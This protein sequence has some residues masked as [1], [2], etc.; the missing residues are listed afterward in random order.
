M[1]E[2]DLEKPIIFKVALVFCVVGLFLFAVA[3]WDYYQAQKRKE[4][5]GYARA[6]QQAALVAEAINVEMQAEMVMAQD[7]ADKLSSGELPYDQAIDYVQPVFEQEP[8]L[9]GM[10]V[11]FEPYMY[12]PSVKLYAPYFLR[13]GQGKSSLVQIENIYDYTDPSVDTAKWYVQAAEAGT[14]V[15]VDPY[16]GRASDAILIVYSV[17]FS[18]PDD[19]TKLAGIV[20]IA[21]SV[22]NTFKNFIQNAD[23]GYGGYLFLVNGKNKITFHPEL[24]LINEDVGKLAERVK[25]FNLEDA[26]NSGNTGQ[27][28]KYKGTIS[29]HDDQTNGTGKLDTSWLFVHEL[30]NP[31]DWKVVVVI[32][33][34]D[35]TYNPT[36]NIRQLVNL[37]QMALMFFVGLAM[38]VIRVDKMTSIRLMIFSVTLGVYFLVGILWIWYLV[39]SNPELNHQTVLVNEA[40][41]QHAL[42]PMHTAFDSF[43][44][45]HP[46]EVPTGILIENLTMGSQSIKISGYLWQNYPLDF[47]EEAI[48]FPQFTDQIGTLVNEEVYR[49]I[50]D[51]RQ[52]VGW[53]FSSE[54]QQRF[55]NQ[56]YP[57]DQAIIK[58]QIEPSKLSEDYI[59]APAT[60]DYDYMGPGFK[61]GLANNL[62][63]RGWNIRNSFFTYDTAGY[64]TNF[65]LFRQIPKDELPNLVYNVRMTRDILSPIIAYCI[66]IYIV[67]MQIYGISVLK[68]EN[69][70]QVLS[71]AAALF[72]VVAITHNS[73]RETV[74]VNGVVYL[75][76]YFILLYLTILA[77]SINAI[78]WAADI[79]VPL[80]S[81]RDNLLIK[82]VFW[83]LFLGIS[84]FFTMLRFYPFNFLK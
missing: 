57:L 53:F 21:H 20:V 39:F 38:L 22:T 77:T 81:Y 2:S 64:G 46:Q 31:A 24:G 63:V 84:L 44:A 5:Q 45:P 26:L 30:T 73:F 33:T 66:V 8:H 70:Y 78:M 54:V 1:T 17:P 43:S 19:E 69:S 11:A 34:L 62:R 59:L 48:N 4:E 6:S 3:G 36:E 25:G 55:E 28:K 71:I 7:V 15:W 32:S 72:L 50:R 47:P 74:A 37:Y 35:K 41:V 65:G 75:E 10:A 82:I 42:E 51:N 67:V 80:L 60:L 12:D 68:I 79:G 76:Y 13:D 49:Y 52:I 58:I 27:E 56:R 29:F 14:A 23:L 83:P 61:P 40:G 18:V 16:Y 9:L